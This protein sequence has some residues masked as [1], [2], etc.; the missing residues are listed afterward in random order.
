MNSILQELL[1][2]TRRLLPY[3][4]QRRQLI[5]LV[6]IASGLPI[7]ELLITKIIVVMILDGDNY[8]TNEIIVIGSALTLALVLVK[9]ANYFQKVS[10]VNFFDRAFKNIDK[11]NG[12]STG[13]W[14]WATAFETINLLTFLTQITFATTFFF[15]LE[16]LI[17]AANLLFVILTIEA[18]GR[19]FQ[20]QNLEQRKFVDMKLNKEFV[21]VSVALSGRIKS[22]ELGTLLA[23]ASMAFMI[24][25]LII[26]SWLDFTTLPNTV[27]C[28]FG[29]RM[30]NSNLSSLSSSL[31][32]LARARAQSS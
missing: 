2:S 7:V 25:I 6:L 28:F 26:L 17:A 5:L 31:M 13:G 11:K 23:S 29:L 10:R 14:K 12:V 24:G 15:L 20:K 4:R 27:V 19:I 22:A 30:I 9:V 3:G 21:D 1:D 8:S 32:R 18:V 16:P